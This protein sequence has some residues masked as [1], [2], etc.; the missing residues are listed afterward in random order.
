MSQSSV[1]FCTYLRK[2]NNRTLLNV[3]D[4]DKQLYIHVLST[5]ET[6][7]TCW[8]IAFRQDSWKN[9]SFY[10]IVRINSGLASI[11]GGASYGKA[12]IF[13]ICAYMHLVYPCREYRANA[14]WPGIRY[15]TE[16]EITWHLLNRRRWLIPSAR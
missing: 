11:R 16:Q 12:R 6:R 4:V 9:R 15:G 13:S 1:L 10:R 8:S 14:A 3:L 7:E 2:R 5:T